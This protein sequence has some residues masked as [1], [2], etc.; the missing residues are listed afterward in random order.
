M[1]TDVTTDDVP[2]WLVDALTGLAAG[3]IDAWLGAFAEDGVHEFPFATAREVR[4]LEG[5][6]AMRAHLTRV[7][8]GVRFGSLDDLRV[9]ATRGGLVVEA[10]GHHEDAATGA[11]FDLRYVWI[12]TH[13][14]GRITLL[15]DYMGPRRPRRTE[16]V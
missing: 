1:P 4:R 9:H 14:A 11:P 12:I 6:E 16:E 5:K 13:R 7:A 10:E 3:D 8:G 15:R 2:S